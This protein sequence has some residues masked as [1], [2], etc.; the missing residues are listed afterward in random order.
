[1]HRIVISDASTLILFQKIDEFELL[2]KI[3]GVLLTTPEIA[4]ESC[5][6]SE[7]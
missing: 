2:T 6:K 7:I 5:F 3:Y 1:M 4:Q